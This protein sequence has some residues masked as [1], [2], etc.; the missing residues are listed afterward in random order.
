V[1]RA[2][3]EREAALITE[4]LRRFLAGEPLRNQVDKR[5]GY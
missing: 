1:T 4:N 2:F 5:A 3:W